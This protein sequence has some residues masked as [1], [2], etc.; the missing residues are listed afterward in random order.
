MRLSDVTVGIAAPG[1]RRGDEQAAH[2]HGKSHEG[3]LSVKNPMKLCG[4]KTRGGSECRKQAGWGTGHAGEGRCRLHGGNA[5][6]PI[7]TG[8]Y[9]LRHRASLEEKATA[10]L[11]DSA[12]GDL[13]GELALMRALLQ[14]YL[15]R[16]PDTAPLSLENIQHIYEML[17][18]IG[19]TVERIARI[20]N[21][22]AL[23]QAEVQFLK[24]RLVDLAVKYVDNSRRD[25]FF[26]ELSAAFGG[27]GGGG[28]S[29]PTC[30]IAGA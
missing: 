13:T 2:A 16:F 6:R 4:A 26:A 30:A 24:A 23:T 25:A 15:E 14:D 20:L 17:E 3:G 12:P 21:Q 10:F 5:G 28:A 7:E 27:G 29:A 18:S 1:E 8:R 9:S 22:T 19:R 11:S